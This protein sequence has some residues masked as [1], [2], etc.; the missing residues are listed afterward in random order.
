MFACYY[1][2][3][4]MWLE[5][6]VCSWRIEHRKVAWIKIEDQAYFI[7][8]GGGGWNGYDMHVERNRAAFR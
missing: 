3:Q 1:Q 6:E 5:R 8:G 4:W 2:N 7:G